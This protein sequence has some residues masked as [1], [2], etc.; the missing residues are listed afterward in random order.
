MDHVFHFLA[1]AGNIEETVTSLP[2]ESV[3]DSMTLLP[4]WGDTLNI[5]GSEDGDRVTI[6]GVLKSPFLDPELAFSGNISR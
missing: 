4:I 5:G 2:T 6:H 1:I 3:N